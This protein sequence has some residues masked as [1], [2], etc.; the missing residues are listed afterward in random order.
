MMSLGIMVGSAQGAETDI[1]A[2]SPMQS[3]VDTGGHTGSVKAMGNANAE[4]LQALVSGA[5][6]DAISGR[7][8]DKNTMAGFLKRT[9]GDDLSTILAGGGANSPGE[10]AQALNSNILTTQWR[11]FDNEG[12]RTYSGTLTLTKHTGDDSVK[13][14]FDFTDD[15]V[16]DMISKAGVSLVKKADAKNYFDPPQQ[17]EPQVDSGYSP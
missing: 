16:R 4:E 8:V 13:V 12:V 17:P 3:H 14:G 1:V 7:M 2:F 15:N 9:S 5:I 11:Q 10:F 6:S